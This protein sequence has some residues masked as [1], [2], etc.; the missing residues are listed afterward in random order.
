MHTLFS[1]EQVQPNTPASFSGIKPGY[2]IF[3]RGFD[4]F[5]ALVLL[6]LLAVP[7]L[8][9]GLIICLDSPGPAIF[10]QNRVGRNGK[11]FA[12]YKF[13]TMRRDA[14]SEMATRDFVDADKYITRVGR[15]LRRFSLDELPQLW[16]VLIGNMSFVGYRP[17]C[18]SETELNE[19]RRENGVFAM[20]PGITGL[21]QIN[22]RDNI[23]MEEKVALDIRYV[24]SCSVGMDI[25][26]LVRTVSVVFN[27]EGV[28]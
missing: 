10:R 21:A 24:Q 15:F 17:I 9:I 26:C 13:R 3:K 4:L 19:L 1:Q 23:S 8:L 2:R 16:N 22:G 25:R 14:P 20:K 5:G 6:V 7:M 12:V 11:A 28:I 27:G 18:V